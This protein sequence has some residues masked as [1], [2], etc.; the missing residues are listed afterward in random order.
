MVL[1]FCCCCGAFALQSRLVLNIKFILF[2][3]ISTK[4][5]IC[6]LLFLLIH[7]NAFYPF[8]VIIIICHQS[9]IDAATKLND[10]FFFGSAIRQINLQSKAKSVKKL[11][12]DTTV[13]AFIQYPF[14]ADHK[15]HHFCSKTFL[16]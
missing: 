11:T 2:I 15:Y 13:I 10:N 12:I 9:K 4:F 5:Y 3:F 14:L 8:M 7:V 6:M 16:Y 1:T